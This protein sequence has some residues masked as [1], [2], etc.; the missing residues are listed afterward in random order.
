MQVFFFS[1]AVH[2]HLRLFTYCTWAECVSKSLIV[3]W[4]RHNTPDISLYNVCAK[5]EVDWCKKENCVAVITP[6]SA[7]LK[8]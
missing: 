5:K 1:S 4:T 3:G 2:D 7:T 6:Q 8:I